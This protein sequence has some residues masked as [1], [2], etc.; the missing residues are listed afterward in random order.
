MIFYDI[1]TIL[2]KNPPC[3][4]ADFYKCDCIY[5][6]YSC[7]YY[8][9]FKKII[10]FIIFIVICKTIFLIQIIISLDLIIIRFFIKKIIYF[11]NEIYITLVIIPWIY[12]NLI[13]AKISKPKITLND[14]KIIISNAIFINIWLTGKFIT[15]NALIL[16]NSWN[17]WERHVLNP[18]R[19]IINFFLLTRKFNF[20]ELNKNYSTL[21]TKRKKK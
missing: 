12:I 10:P 17:E 3:N 20:N 6:W 14:L 7:Y 11:E 16:L 5:S 21:F 8:V 18:K 1:Y 9:D 15:N 2:T 13:I 19:E 4:W